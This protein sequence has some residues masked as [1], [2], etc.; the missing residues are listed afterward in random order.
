MKTFSNP[1]KIKAS[2]FM[3]SVCKR[4]CFVVVCLCSRLCFSHSPRVVGQHA[5]LRAGHWV[6]LWCFPLNLLHSESCSVSGWPAAARA[7]RVAVLKDRLPRSDSPEWRGM[8]S[9]THNSC[10]LFPTVLCL[11]TGDKS[12]TFRQLLLV[13]LNEKACQ[14]GLSCRTVC[15]QIVISHVSRGT[16]KTKTL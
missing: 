8:L 13:A 4:G 7:P 3:E 6:P 5:S 12:L 9:V 16:K 1:N 10:C 11:C 2:F 15:P 14:R